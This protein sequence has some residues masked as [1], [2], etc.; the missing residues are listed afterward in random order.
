VG[1]GWADVARSRLSARSP[2]A[3]ALPGTPEP[4]GGDRAAAWHAAW[5]E[6]RDRPLLGA[7]P[8]RRDLSW[9]GDDGAVYAARYVHNEYLELAASQGLAGIAALA[10]AVGL[11]WRWAGRSPPPAGAL[12]GP[13]GGVAAAVVTFAVHSAFDYLWHVPVLPVTLALLVGLTVGPEAGSGRAACGAEGDGRDEGPGHRVPS[14][15]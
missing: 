12:R 14:R 15:Q 6:L 1:D 7:G 4:L 5:D 9:V 13:R 8:E 2:V 11:V 3:G 10:L